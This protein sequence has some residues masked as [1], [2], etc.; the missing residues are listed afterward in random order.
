MDDQQKTK[1]KNYVKILNKTIVDDDLLDFVI[2]VTVDRVLL[3]LNQDKVDPRI[4]RVVAQVVVSSFNKMNKEVNNTGSQER[5]IKS[6]SDNGQS[7]TYSDKVK[8]YMATAEDDELFS[9]FKELLKP[10][11]RIHVIAG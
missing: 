4:N 2:D 10:Y 6:I 9:G 5:E 3:Y 8:S 1:I 11:R 7:I